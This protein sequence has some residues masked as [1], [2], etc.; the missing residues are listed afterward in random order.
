VLQCVFDPRTSDCG[1]APSVKGARCGVRDARSV[2]TD[3][4]L[5]TSHPALRTSLPALDAVGAVLRERV[6]V[7]TIAVAQPR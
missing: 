5:R 3:P 4:A 1:V 6:L 2:R 7:N